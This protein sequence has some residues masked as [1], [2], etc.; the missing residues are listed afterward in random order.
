MDQQT[1]RQYGYSLLDLASGN[2]KL[3][4]ADSQPGQIA[5]LPDGSALFILFAD[6]APWSVK[7]VD[8]AGFA[9]D[10]IGI[11]S[12][13]TGIGFVPK[14]EQVFVSQAQSDGRI[15]FIE[16]NSL[17]IKSVAGYELNSSIWE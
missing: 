1:A 11:G 3:L 12:Q 4:L 5:A 10:S 9:V 2:S 16:W 6:A 8:L 17:R 13:P 15:T 7:R 14:A